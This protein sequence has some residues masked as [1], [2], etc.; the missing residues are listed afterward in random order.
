MLAVKLAEGDCPAQRVSSRM[1]EHRASEAHSSHE[2]QDPRRPCAG[3]PSVQQRRR[4]THAVILAL[5]GVLTAGR[6]SATTVIPIADRDLHDR[7]DVIVHGVVVSSQ[8]EEDPSGRP[9]TVSVI[10]PLE[11]LKGRLA[12]DLVLRQLGGE[13]PDGRFLKIWGRPEYEPGRQVLV[14]AIERPDGD[15]QT[16][17]QLL[18]KFEVQDDE[19]GTSFAVPA[20]AA[21]PPEVQ[22]VH[23]ASS[24]GDGE[25]GPPQA[26]SPRELSDFLRFLRQPD[27]SALTTASAPRG[28]LRAVRSPRVCRR[29]ASLVE[30]Y[31]RQPLAM[32][33]RR[34][35]RLDAGRAGQHNGWRGRRGRLCR[36]DVERRVPRRDQLHGRIGQLQR[37]PLERALLSVRMEYV[38]RRRRRHRVR[39]GGGQRDQ[40]V[41]RRELRHDHQRRGVAALVLQLQRL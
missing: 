2:G 6:V 32:E 34:D 33:Q 7:A 38:P 5:F 31:R 39:L 41:A 11:V 24:D 4:V 25:R 16:A 8:V 14:F 3:G 13:L 21:Q 1:P 26:T 22:V 36:G 28:E 20:L 12:G 19:A 37:R 30:Q 40:P 15:H 35:G 29:A 10:E 27:E 9:V 18:G 23:A 17:E